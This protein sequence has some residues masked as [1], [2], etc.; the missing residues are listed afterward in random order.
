MRVKLGS[1]FDVVGERRQTDF[2]VD[3]KAKWLEEA[4]EIKLR[5]HKDQPVEVL[6]KENLY[7]WSNW[8]LRLEDARLH[9]GRCAHHSL[10]GEG[11]QGWRNR[12][13]LP[14][15]LHLVSDSISPGSK[16]SSSH[17]WDDD[18]SSRP[19]PRGEAFDRNTPPSLKALNV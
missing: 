7:R 15:A 6:V 1:A 10:P 8:T 12:R 16:T 11:R 13:A 19:A 2:K 3:T 18:A 5:N 17:E 14:R 9:Q 4:F